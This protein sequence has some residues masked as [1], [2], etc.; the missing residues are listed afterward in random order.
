M[1]VHVYTWPARYGGLGIV[2]VC[3][4]ALTSS[5]RASICSLSRLYSWAFSFSLDSSDGP[6]VVTAW[7]G[8][9]L[10]WGE[11]ER[12]ESDMYMCMCTHRRV[13]I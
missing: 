13:C 3:Q 4:G 1:H 2:H 5:F 9:S 12:E 6:T 10:G 7:R 11:G 8:D